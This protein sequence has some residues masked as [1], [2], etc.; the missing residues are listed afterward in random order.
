MGRITTELTARSFRC[1]RQIVRQAKIPAEKNRKFR[2]FV[3]SF[4]PKALWHARKLGRGAIRLMR[5]CIRVRGKGQT[6]DVFQEIH[7]TIGDG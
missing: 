3:V 2:T 5:G 1:Q 6:I 4:W 7:L